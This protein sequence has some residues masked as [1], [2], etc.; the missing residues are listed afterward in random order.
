MAPP[1]RPRVA[2]LAGFVPRGVRTF[3]GEG[4]LENI[5]GIVSCAR[6]LVA[7]NPFGLLR[8]ARLY[9]VLTFE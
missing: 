3:K 5:P 7:S 1:D 6:P 9:R 8:D 2:V 4:R